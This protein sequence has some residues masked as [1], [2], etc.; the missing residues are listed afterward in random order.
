MLNIGIIGCGTIGINICRAV[1]EGLIDAHIR[2]IYDRHEDHVKIMKASLKHLQPEV[3]E[4]ARVFEH[5]DLLVEC[6]SQI[7]VPEII[8]AALRAKCDVMIMSVGAFA[9]NELYNEIREIAKENIGIARVVLERF[10]VK[11]VSED[12]GGA[13]GRKLVYNTFS[14]EAVVYKTVKLRHGD[15]Y[16]Y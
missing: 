12:V 14:N 5:I 6:A 16:P 3:M 8:P 11:I 2:A 15:W 7:A 1:D 13:V 9:D 10:R 4:P